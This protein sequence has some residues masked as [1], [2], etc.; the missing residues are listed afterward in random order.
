MEEK[1][2]V[3]TIDGTDMSNRRGLTPAEQAAMMRLRDAFKRKKKALG[4][5]YEKVSELAGWSTSA[6]GHYFTGFAPINMPALIKICSIIE[7]DP[8]SIYPELFDGI[9]IKL[10]QDKDESWKDKFYELDEQSQ[11]DIIKI[12]E[13][14]HA[15]FVRN[16]KS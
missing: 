8:K 13:T 2:I 11:Q 10:S 6:A 15:A 4:L 9:S 16:N 7:E 1:I 14:Y 3:K 12:I 5:T